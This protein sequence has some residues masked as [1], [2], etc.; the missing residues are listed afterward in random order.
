[1]KKSMLSVVLIGLF[2]LVSHLAFAQ[3]DQPLANS[4]AVAVNQEDTNPDTASVPA[5]TES[6]VDVPLANSDNQ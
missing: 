2:L 5:D 4:D 1:M 3:E 6:N